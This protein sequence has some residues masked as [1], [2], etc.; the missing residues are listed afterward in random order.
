MTTELEKVRQEIA[1]LGAQIPH[2]FAR[3]ENITRQLYD[4]LSTPEWNGISITTR[5]LLLEIHKC[6]EELREIKQARELKKS[7]RDDLADI[8]KLSTHYAHNVVIGQET[9]HNG[10]VTS[11]YLYCED[12]DSDLI[13]EEVTT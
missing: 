4:E 5:N 6:H 10:E 3:R 1:D 2:I 13:I 7:L 12:C 8:S 9:D 11:N